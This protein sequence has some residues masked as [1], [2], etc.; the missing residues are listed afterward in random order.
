MPQSLPIPANSLV[1]PTAPRKPPKVSRY[2]PGVAPSF[3]NEE[4]KGKKK[5]EGGRKDAVVDAEVLSA[6]QEEDPRLQRLKRRG[7]VKVERGERRRRVHH[8]EILSTD[9]P[10]EEAAAPTKKMKIKAEVLESEEGPKDQGDVKKEGGGGEEEEEE[11]EEMHIRRFRARLRFNEKNEDQEDEM[12]QDEIDQLLPGGED[13]VLG[14]GQ[15]SEEEESEESESEYETDSED[16][17]DH[18]RN[19]LQPIFVSAAERDTKVEQARIEKEKEKELE[20]EE[21]RKEERKKET[22]LRVEEEVKK[23]AEA[24]LVVEEDNEEDADDPA[25]E[26]EERKEYEAWKVRELAR[27]RKAQVE[28]EKFLEEEREKEKRSQMTDMEI[29]AMDSKT[30]KFDKKK[31]SMKFLQ[32]YYHKGA[33]F[34]DTEEEVLKRDTSAPTGMDKIDK[35][36]LPSVLQVKNFGRSGQTKYTHLVDQDTLGPQKAGKSAFGWGVDDDLSRKYAR[37]MGGGGALDDRKRKRG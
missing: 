1:K 34:Q 18:R 5:K 2:R 6:V 31:Q 35:S 22:L 8:A 19:E 28:K 26:E 11:E 37:K 25:N 30:G 32:K 9:E 23:D 29:R 36:N 17:W 4:E 12:D 24:A 27:I 10:E 33:F 16:E 3:A 13:D 21:K 15:M 20:F 7:D 14:G